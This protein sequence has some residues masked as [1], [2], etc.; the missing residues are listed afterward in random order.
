MNG[1]VVLILLVEPP[2]NPARWTPDTSAVFAWLRAIV[3]W[4]SPTVACDPKSVV[5]SLLPIP[6]PSLP[7]VLLV[8]VEFSNPTVTAGFAFGALTPIPPPLVLAA[9]PEM[10]ER[11]VEPP[12]PASN[13]I[14]PP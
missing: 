4:S 10:V 9:L 7:A 1:E 8:S 6:P 13:A 12:E 14:P 3:T 2:P 11:L 5:G